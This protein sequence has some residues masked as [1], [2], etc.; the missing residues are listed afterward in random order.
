MRLA[1]FNVNEIHIL[2]KVVFDGVQVLPISK[3][4]K[5]SLP[6]SQNSYM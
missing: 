3:K 2:R 5:Q 4:P 1:R 6:S